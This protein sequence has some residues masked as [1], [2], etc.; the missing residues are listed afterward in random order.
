MTEVFQFALLG[1]GA[2][3]IYALIGQGLVLI[4]RGSGILNLAHG[5]FAMAGA[6]VFYE[7]HV[8]QE[9]ATA[10]AMAASVLVL[11]LIGALVDQI[12]LRR[13]RGASALARLIGTLGIFIV[14]QSVATI[15]YGAEP[16]LIEPVLQ[17]TPVDI[18]GATV[19]SDRLWLLAI[20]A[21]LSAALWVMW[22]YS[23]IGWA[24]S[25]VSENQRAAAAL[26]WSPERI[27]ALTWALGAGLAGLAGILIAPITSLSVGSL[28]LLVIPGLAAAL[29]GGFVSFPLTLAGGV[30]L[31]I[32]QSEVQRYVTLTGAA[33]SVPFLVI[34]VMLALRGSALPQRGYITDRLPEVGLGR[35]RPAQAGVALA[36]AALLVGFVLSDAYLSAVIVGLSVGIVLLSLVALTGFSGQLSLAQFAL[37]GIGALAAARLVE[38]QDFPFPLALVGG[39]VATTLFGLLLALPALRTRG[40]ELAAVTLGLG[41]AAEA[42]LFN[43][44]DVTSSAAGTPIGNPSLFGL[45]VSAFDHP[46]RYALLAL[47]TFTLCAV[48]VSNLR[49]GRSG[50]RLLAVRTNERA[51]AAMGINVFSAKLHAFAVAGALAGIGGVILAFRASTVIYDQFGPLDS[52]T[53]VS[54]AMIGGIGYVTGPLLGAILA[55][56]SLGQQL[57]GSD[58][59]QAAKYLPLISGMLLLALLVAAPNGLAHAARR[60]GALVRRRTRGRDARPSTTLPLT[61]EARTRVPPRHLKVH[62]LAVHYGGVRAVDGVGFTLEPGRIVGLIGPNGAGKTSVVDAISGFTPS[63]GVVTIDDQDISSW[64][65]HRRARGGMVRSFQALE[66]FEDMTVLENLQTAGDA[67]D[68][69][70]MV[71]DLVAPGR[72]VLH[73]VAV[74]AVDE[75]ELRRVLDRRPSELPYG[76]RRLVAIARAIAMEPSILLLDEPAAGLDEGES[77][78]LA[79]LVRKLADDW[80]IAVLLIEHDMEFVMGICDRVLVIDFGRPIAAGTPAEVRADPNAIAAY[81]GEE[82]SATADEPLPVAS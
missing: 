67:R 27:S 35:L 18:L 48:V 8:S 60:V 74:A 56:G 13:L 25:A 16:K 29:I 36:V 32:A 59:E 65:A 15:R 28:S 78:E 24:M 23:R 12:L 61:E 40:V 81:L 39:V 3:A 20:A 58:A 63:S 71:T 54:Q 51:A 37:A 47:V 45:D 77:R 53:A 57:S 6:Y 9:L 31:G 14:V 46:V 75:F 44:S 22:R 41:A 72:P 62:D 69:L 42:M 7:L 5:A 82:T 79:A 26:G 38:S 68:N 34:V 64:P 2:G 19:S 49:R 76:Q 30:V 55:P 70:A 66:L 4:F 10:P 21:G 50:R 1:L 33:T 80:G 11:A 43:N 52:I 73:P 17:Q